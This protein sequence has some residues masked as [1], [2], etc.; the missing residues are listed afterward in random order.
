LKGFFDVDSD[1][2]KNLQMLWFELHH[3]SSFGSRLKENFGNFRNWKKVFYHSG[4][5]FAK[6]KRRL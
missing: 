2:H 1:F 5:A 6:K 3:I 4:E